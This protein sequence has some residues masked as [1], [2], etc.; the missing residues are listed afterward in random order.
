MNCKADRNG[1]YLGMKKKWYKGLLLIADFIPPGP[2]EMEGFHVE[3]Q[4]ESITLLGFN[5]QH[6]EVTDITVGEAGITFFESDHAVQQRPDLLKRYRK[7]YEFCGGNDIIYFNVHWL[8]KDLLSLHP[9]WFQVYASGEFIPIGY[10]SGGYSCINSPFRDWAFHIVK[11]IGKYDVKGIFLDGPVFNPNGCYCEGC[12]SRFEKKNGFR[13]QPEDMKNIHIHKKVLQF[14]HESIAEFLREGRAALKSVNPEGVIY[15]N[16]LPLGPSTCGRDNRT[17]IEHQDALLAEG[18]FLSGNL[19]DIPV[20]KP[21]AS[22]KLLETQAEGKPSIVAVAGRH[23]GWNRYLLSPEETWITYALSV[24]NGANIWYGV[25]DSNRTDERMKTVKEINSFLNAN[26]KYL[27][28]TRADAKIALVWSTKNANLYQ[29]TTEYWDFVG[30]RMKAEDHLKSDSRRA[31]NGWFE[32][33]QRSHSIFDVIDDYSVEHREISKYELVILPDVACMSENEVKRIRDYVKNGGN[34]IATY[35]TS[36]YDDS[37]LPSKNMQLAEVLNIRRIEGTQAMPFDHILVE[38]GMFTV[39]IDQSLIPSPEQYIKVVPGDHC[40]R[41]M[42]FREK[43][44]SRYCDLPEKTE[45]PFMT[46]NKYGQGQAVLFAGSIDATYDKFKF[47]EF[48][49]L[50]RN[51]VEELSTRSIYINNTITSLF[52]NSRRKGDER[53]IHLVNYTSYG[54]RPISHIIPLKDLKIKV[55]CENRPTSV[56]ALRTGI[57]LEYTFE[58]GLVLFEIPQVLAYEIVVIREESL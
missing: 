17:C 45:Y 2:D 53:I 39:G 29:T 57:A 3:E 11:D 47:P 7:S 20:W 28:G 30:E 40:E 38:H 49:T 51:T 15:M 13:Y 1:G 46:R 41:Y 36:C 31:F 27:E 34:I 56:K 54:G 50:M 14:K 44:L 25:Y 12:L 5:S 32:V 35:D 24:A 55:R 22:A 23:S 52:V 43:Q 58:E 37:G 6:I 9:E 21:A 4:V 10:G 8:N 48:F 26:V 42:C 16:G 33:L 19:R 18:G